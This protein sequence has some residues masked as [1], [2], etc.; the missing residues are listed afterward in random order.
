MCWAWLGLV[1]MESE[2]GHSLTAQGLLASLGERD[3]GRS[4]FW[5]LE[6]LAS[7]GERDVGKGAMVALGLLAA[8]WKQAV[9]NGMSLTLWEQDQ[10]W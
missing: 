6:L 8:C 9:G 5:A 1:G 4:A 3:V 7:L 2:L 10:I